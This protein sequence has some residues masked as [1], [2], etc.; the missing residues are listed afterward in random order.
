MVGYIS[1]EGK[2]KKKKKTTEK[3]QNL[4]KTRKLRESDK[5]Q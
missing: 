2:E 1:Q 3:L 5:M 4:V